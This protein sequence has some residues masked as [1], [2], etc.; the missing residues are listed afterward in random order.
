MRDVVGNNPLVSCII[1]FF[2]VE[3]YIVEAIES[4]L[5]QT[6]QNWEL[7]LVDDGSRD[8]STEVA[9]RYARQYPHKIFY[10][11][12]EGH[13]NYGM[14]ASRNLGIQQ[15]KGKLIAFLD[16]DDIWLPCKLEQQLECFATHPEAGMVYGRTVIWHSW[17]GLAEDADR[18]RI[19]PL[20]VRPDSLIPPPELL[21]T[22]LRGNSQTPTICNAI[23]K[24]EVFE[25]VG[26]FEEAFR[27]M[28]EDQVLYSKV[29]L[30]IPVFVS[31]CCWA[32]YRQ[33]PHGCYNLTTHS[34]KKACAA[35]LLFLRWLKTY[36]QQQEA[37]NHFIWDLLNKDITLCQNPYL[38]RMWFNLKGFLVTGGRK[39]LPY[40][41]RDWLWSTVGRH[42]W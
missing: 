35:R 42:M 12:H 31:D 25:Q 7:L 21:I 40:R 10:V 14:S 3:R 41:V 37:R 1:I 17:T 2:N 30:H 4:V 11:D 33:H 15:S 18:D 16:A 6:Y 26:Y 9:R 39:I 13:Q 36:L 22:L 38:Y 23:L 24:K 20:G 8:G 27:G 5:A 19:L 34:F 28:Y 29:L 32:K